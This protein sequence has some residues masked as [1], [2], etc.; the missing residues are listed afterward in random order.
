[1][2]AVI[3]GA[4]AFPR[5]AYPRYLIG[6]ADLVICCDSA[7][8]TYLAAMPSIFGGERLPDAIV[9]DM[10]SLSAALQKKYEGRIVKITEQDDNDQTKAMRHLLS[11]GKDIDTIHFIGATGRRADHTVGNL[12]L[13]MEYGRMF[14]LEGISID[15]VSDYET[16][17]PIW[18]SATLMV[19]RG[20]RVSIFSPDN[21]LKI[22]S[23][24]LK[25]DTSGVVFDNWWKATLNTAV[26][27]E[28]QLSFSHPSA[29]LICL[30]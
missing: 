13:L 12:S 20:R 11:L 9:G 7:L 19:G 17:F 30:D 25:Y 10:D 22:T 16:V 2:T 4:G 18:D 21:S 26:E 14:N 23:S 24:G 6:A 1:M 8:K 15:A 28:I 29:A 5:K 3:I 27:D